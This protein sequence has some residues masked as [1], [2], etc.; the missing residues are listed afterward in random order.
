MAQAAKTL[1]ISYTHLIS[2]LNWLNRSV[3]GS[4]FKAERGGARGGW[5]RLTPLGESLLQDY[6]SLLNRVEE[7]VREVNVKGTLEKDL[8]IIG[9]SLIHI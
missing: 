3:G 9:L 4:V 5:A 1:G 7:A 2:Y 8:V 6:R